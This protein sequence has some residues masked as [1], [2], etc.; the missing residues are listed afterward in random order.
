MIKRRNIPLIVTL[1]ACL[2]AC[3]WS[4]EVS[5][6]NASATDGGEAT[7]TGAGVTSDPP[8]TTTSTSTTTGSESTSS[9][10][11]QG[12]TSSEGSGS[13]TDGDEGN[14]GIPAKEIFGMPVCYD[15]NG[16]IPHITEGWIYSKEEQAIHGDVNHKALDIALPY[17]SPVFAMADGYALASFETYPT[18]SQRGQEI[19]LGG[20]LLVVIWHPEL[21][22]FTQYL[23][24]S[25]I[26]QTMPY[27]EPTAYTNSDGFE[28]WT[29]SA[30]VKPSTEFVTQQVIYVKQGD[31][32]GHIGTSGLALNQDEVPSA[33]PV[34]LGSWDEPHLHVQAH[35]DRNE[36]GQRD[37]KTIYDMTDI[38]ESAD[39]ESEDD[40]PYLFVFEI[41]LG[42]FDCDAMDE[43][44]PLYPEACQELFPF[45]D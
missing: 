21:Q 38:Y 26:T 6:S 40:I 9:S 33:N 22:L 15:N 4:V 17:G 16:I 42:M 27:H 41:C 14:N 29:P 19:G 31:L 8:S 13:T 20:G 7:T 1:L 43:L 25:D 45:N 3:D 18:F 36:E 37:P 5:T 30:I 28:S 24:L 34:K 44:F 39:G 35:G 23:H 12:S 10:S 11:G 2:A 32:I